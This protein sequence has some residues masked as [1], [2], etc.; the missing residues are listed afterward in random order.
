M[1]SDIKRPP[2]VMIPKIWLKE[3]MRVLQDIESEPQNRSSSN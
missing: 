3:L 2:L 1:F